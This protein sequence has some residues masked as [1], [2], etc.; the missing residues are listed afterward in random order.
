MRRV[1]GD[2]WIDKTALFAA[3]LGIETSTH[4][5]QDEK[6]RTFREVKAAF[7]RSDL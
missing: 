5:W 1:Y 2:E 7:K 4:Y 6:S 3:K